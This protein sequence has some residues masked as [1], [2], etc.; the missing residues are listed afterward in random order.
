MGTTALSVA[1]ALT[2]SIVVIRLF[3][4]YMPPAFSIALLPFVMRSPTV[5]Y[6]ISVGLGALGLIAFFLLYQRVMSS[7][8][9][10][11]L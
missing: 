11:S 2:V 4:V 5:T 3:R 8:R 7:A 6:A 10:R 9:L 1:F